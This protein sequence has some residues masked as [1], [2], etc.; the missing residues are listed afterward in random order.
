MGKGPFIA[1]AVFT[2]IVLL[3]IPVGYAGTYFSMQ[4]FY[5]KSHLLNNED[6]ILQYFM[7]CVALLSEG[8]VF[9]IENLFLLW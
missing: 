1:F 5:F 6:I 2:K 8:N 4:C 9:V 7:F 3:L